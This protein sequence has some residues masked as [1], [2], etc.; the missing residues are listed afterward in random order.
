MSFGCDDS[1][2][3]HSSHFFPTFTSRTSHDRFVDMYFQ[4]PQHAT[5]WHPSRK[6]HKLL[7]S[8]PS[9]GHS[10]IN[11]ER[12]TGWVKTRVKATANNTSYP[13][14]AIWCIESFT[15]LMISSTV[16]RASSNSAVPSEFLLHLSIS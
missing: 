3:L 10:M 12:N 6:W 14:I 8:V 13:V 16:A 5:E 15:D 1:E 2:G 11:D 7:Q 9:H 4:S